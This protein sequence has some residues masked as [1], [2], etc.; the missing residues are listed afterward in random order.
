M[1]CQRHYVLAPSL[2]YQWT[3]RIVRQPEHAHGVAKAQGFDSLGF[4]SWFSSFTFIKKKKK[5]HDA[6]LRWV[7]HTSNR[8]IDSDC[9]LPRFRR[10]VHNLNGYL[11]PCL[12][13]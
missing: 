3:S 9:H 2:W 4:P 12:V 1:H 6:F 13:I 10:R 11:V 5:K 8:I 7:I